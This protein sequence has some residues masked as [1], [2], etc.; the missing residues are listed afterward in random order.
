MKYSIFLDDLREIS[1]VY[2]SEDGYDFL[3]CRDFKEAVDLI[4]RKGFMPS[5]I[6][7]DNDLGVF[8]DGSNKPEGRDLVNWIVN[9]LLDGEL[10]LPDDFS[11]YVHSANPVASD[12]IN[13]TML[14][15]INHIKSLK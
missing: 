14:N 6:S 11:Y 4:L 9:G 12:Y 1:D 3:I 2:N 13:G 10:V 8:E 5:Y 15:I 7:F